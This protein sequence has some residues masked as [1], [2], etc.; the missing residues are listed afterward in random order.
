M[1][2]IRITNFGGQLPIRDVRQ[3]PDTAAVTALD[4]RL[5]SG[6]IEGVRRNRLI[7]TVAAGTKHVYRVPTGAAD[8][9][10]AAYWMAFADEHTDVVRTP[11]VND[12]F[13]RYYWCSPSTG[14]RYAT[15]AMILAGN[16]TGL[17]LGV[18]RPA[19]A[20]AVSVVPGTGAIDPET[21]ENTAPTVTRSYVV[22]FVSEFGEEGQPSDSAEA[23]GPSDADWQVSSIPQPVVE[24]G[25]AVVT[26]IRIYRT[27]TGSDGTTTFFRVVDLAPGTTVYTDRLSDIVVS[28]QGELGSTIWAGPPAGLQGLALMPNGIFVSWVGNTLY[29]SENYRPHAWP[30]E[31]QI[32]VQHP[33]VGLAVFGNS[34]LVLTQGNPAIVTGTQ[35]ATLTLTTMDAPL[36]CLSRKSIVSAPEGVYFA[37]TGGLALVN[38]GGSQVL[39]DAIIGREKWQ[40]YAPGA[41][42]AVKAYGAYTAALAP[43]TGLAVQVP[44]ASPDAGGQSGVVFLSLPTTTVYVGTDVWS[45]KPWLLDGTTLYEWLPVET[46]PKAYRW[47]SKEF[48]LPAP[49]NLGVAQVRFRPADFSPDPGEVLLTLRVWANGDLVYEQEVTSLSNRALR[50]P[51]GFRADTWQ[52]EVEGALPVQEIVLAR[53]VTELRG[54]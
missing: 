52:V 36:P 27:V 2:G 44:A 41:M 22:T 14:L 4:T 30:A 23:T 18:Q 28:G 48:V 54:V 42:R 21:G 32:T 35:A 15:K 20:P 40:G 37:T 53:T 51:T 6:A 12:S 17:G 7:T 34:C 13:E 47:R 25:K 49:Q 3:L 26:T 43:V 10:D 46:R 39:T 50:L 8:V 24:S 1:S 31:Y 16:L 45:G 29:F 9:I 11:I 19:A 38:A 33:V 5:V